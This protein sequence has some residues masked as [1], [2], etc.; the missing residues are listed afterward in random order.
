MKKAFPGSGPEVDAYYQRSGQWILATVFGRKDSRDWCDKKGVTFTKAQ[1][2]GIGSA[3]G[4]L[5]P[6]ELENAILDLRDSY[7]ALRRRACV[8]PMGSDTSIFPRRTGGTTAYF[9]AEGGTA[10]STA[11]AMDGVALTAKKLGALVTLSNELAEDSIVDIVDFVANEIARTLA[12]KEDDCGF[13]GDGTSGFGGMRG[14]MQ[15]VLDGAHAAAKVTAAAGHN[16]FA[17]LDGTDLSLLMTKVRASAM[18]RAAWFVSVTGFAQTFARLAA[19][20]G[21]GYLYTGEVDGIPTPYF[22]G[23]PIIMSQKLPQVA[24]TLTGQGMLAFGDLY[25]ATV[26]GQRRGLTIARSDHRYLDTDQLGLLC[27]ERFDAVAHDLGDATTPGS[28]A[29]LVAP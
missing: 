3:G 20:A 25:A 2:E 17:T 26:L 27:T 23:F 10:Q 4:F 6:L 24:T 16:T 29:V 1:A 22:N 14:I 11:A 18:A 5:V 21:G 7:G 9:I 12:A 28:V 13:N 8:W 15:I 19:G